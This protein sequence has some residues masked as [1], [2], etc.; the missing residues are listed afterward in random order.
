MLSF[1]GS[2]HTGVESGR[3]FLFGFCQNLQ[4]NECAGFHT[5]FVYGNIDKTI[6]V[7]KRFFLLLSAVAVLS[8]CAVRVF[9]S[10]TSSHFINQP[11]I[12]TSVIADLDVSKEKITYI[13]FPTKAVQKTIYKN[14]INTAVREALRANGDADVLVSPEY[15]VKYVGLFKHKVSMVEVSGY[16]AKYVNFRTPSSADSCWMKIT[17][18]DY[19]KGSS[20]KNGSVVVIK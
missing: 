14:V 5:F 8:G 9:N 3:L 19:R 10:S 11:S 18:E 2:V 16:P 20:A 4:T 15:Q 6:K 17:F 12:A 7:M 1:A 13:Y